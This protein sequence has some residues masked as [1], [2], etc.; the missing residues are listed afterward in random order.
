MTIRDFSLPVHRSIMKRDLYIGIP[1]IPLLIMIFITL[2]MVLDLGQLAFI[3]I[4]VV[5]LMVLKYLTDQDEWLLDIV[6]LSLF[7]P[8]RLR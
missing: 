7:Q 4:A 1:L 3:P 8:D 2:I 6:L 5:I